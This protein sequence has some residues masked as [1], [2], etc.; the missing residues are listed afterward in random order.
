MSAIAE[1]IFAGLAAAA[2]LPAVLYAE[3]VWLA[4]ADGGP[5]WFGWAFIALF[6]APVYWTVGGAASIVVEWAA[7]RLSGIGAFR[8]VSMYALQVVGYAA[9]GYVVYVML[10]YALFGR[11]NGGAVAWQALRIGIPAALLY[12]HAALAVRALSSHRH[13]KRFG[14]PV[15]TERLVL[16]PCTLGR[17]EAARREGYPLGNH[18]K[19]Y[20]SSLRRY[21]RLLGWG[22]WLVRLKETGQIVGDAGFKGNPDIAGAVDIG[23]GFLPEHR[24]KGYA[25]E[26]AR[27]LVAWAFEHGAGRVTAETLRDNAAS[28]RVLRKAGFQLYR[29][30]EHYYWRL[31]LVDRLRGG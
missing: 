5:P 29:E 23:Y 30:D 3:R 17:Y 4:G 1:R 6:A 19:T 26:T 14:A 13:A 25:T 18:V 11:S 16:E 9:M 2:A 10:A 28:I 24:G 22:V 20:I 21:P 27:A 7:E 15:T 12:G 31:D 8:K